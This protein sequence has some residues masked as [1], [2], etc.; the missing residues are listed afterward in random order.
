M[1]FKLQGRPHWSQPLARDKSKVR[2]PNQ[3]HGRRPPE[4]TGRAGHGAPRYVRQEFIEPYKVTAK[5][6]GRIPVKMRPLYVHALLHGEIPT[7]VPPVPQ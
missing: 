7:P 6:R 2:S 1:R 3:P 4:K 5:K